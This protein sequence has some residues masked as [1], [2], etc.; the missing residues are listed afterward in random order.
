MKAAM[1]R[2]ATTPPSIATLIFLTAISVMSLNMFLPSL[3]AIAR[4]FDANYALMNLS[5]AGYLLITAFL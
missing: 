2:P 5:I 1:L 3:A 4:E